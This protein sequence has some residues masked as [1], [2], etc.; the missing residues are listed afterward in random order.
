MPVSPSTDAAVRPP[1]L[2]TAGVHHVSINVKDV[3]EA[4]RFYT[5]VLGL[6]LRT[7]RPDFA[8]GGAWIDVGDQQLH[9]I[10]GEVPEA[11]GQHFAFAV[12][13]LDAAVAGLRVAGIEITDPRPV[14]PR[15]Q[16]FFSDPA[17]NYL[18]LLEVGSG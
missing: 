3:G 2:R 1:T 4:I 10:E 18:E 12:E 11:R 9:L 7:D 5:E 8:F 16:S 17:G 15:R 6:P 14:G 13:D